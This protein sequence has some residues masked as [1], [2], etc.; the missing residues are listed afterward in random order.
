M[1]DLVP[2]LLTAAV[3]SGSALAMYLW[4][5]M[6][7]DPSG[8]ERLVGELRLA[9]W[10]ALA[11]A[12][13]GGISMGLAVAHAAAPFGTVE[14]TLGLAFIVAAAV[15]LQRE[16][17]EAL[18]YAALAFVLHALVTLMHRP[19]GLNPIAPAWFS[20][21]GA[22]FDIFFAAVCYWARRR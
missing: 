7:L 17:R 14:V 11:L 8:P 2:T 1:T 4:R 20:A 5:M 16:P 18:L 15:I 19:G 21:G 3:L 9:R 13:L 12:G 10:A 22:I 6:R